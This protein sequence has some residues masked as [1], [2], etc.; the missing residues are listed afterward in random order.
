MSCNDWKI[1]GGMNLE[2]IE[3]RQNLATTGH[4]RINSVLYFS[5]RFGGFNSVL[6]LGV[7]FGMRIRKISDSS[8]L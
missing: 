1:G 6:Y 7:R 5:V 8:I 4:T 3:T 2:V